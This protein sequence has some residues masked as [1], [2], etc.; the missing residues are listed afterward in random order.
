MSRRLSICVAASEAAPLAKTGGLADVTAALTRELHRRGDDVRL[1]LPFYDTIDPALVAEAVRVELLQEM[2]VEL[3]GRTHRVSV[4][5]LPLPGNP[6]PAIY[7]VDSPA[8]YRRGRIYT[9]DDDET[10]RFACFSRAVLESCQR[11]GWGPDVVHCNDWHTALVPLYLDTDFSWDRL[12]AGTRTLLT[13]HNIAYQGVVGSDRLDDL[14]LA[15]KTEHLETADLA[16][17]R[18]NPLA[19]G[20]RHADLLSTVSPTHAEEIQQSE[21]G[22][23][24]DGL[25]RQRSGDLVGILNGV[26]YDEWDPAVDPYLP[27]N[28]SPDDLSGKRRTKHAVLADA[29]LGGDGLGR[30]WAAPLLG[31]VS[32][33]TAQKGFDLLFDV[34]PQALART[35][36]R[37][38]ALGTGERRYEEFFESLQSRFPERVVFCRG[39]SEPLAHQ[40]EAAS[41]IFLMP[42]RYEPCGLNQMYS[43]RYGTV[44]VV[45]RTGGL[46]DTVVPFDPGRDMGT[47]FVFDHFTPAGLAWAL[48][49]ALRTYEEDRDAWRRLQRRGMAEDFSWERQGALYEDLYRSL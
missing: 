29:G 35:D 32:R 2:A 4:W 18:I 42:S 12:F 49:F 44:P 21:Y 1:F 37:L 30:D 25:L 28:Y 16:A 19:T 47:G 27:H 6:S 34:L 40:I 48:D 8:L 7:L 38:L 23:G 36:A 33:L 22:M 43:L 5:T 39:Y 9:G 20:I 10:M 26:D 31:V 15:D 17:G 3:G 11:M 13:I 45:R 24:L 41:D 14:G 46:A